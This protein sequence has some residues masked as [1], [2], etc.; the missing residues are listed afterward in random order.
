[1]NPEQNWLRPGC[2]QD[3]V[4]LVIFFFWGGRGGGGTFPLQAKSM[5]EQKQPRQMEKKQ[6]PHTPS[7]AGSSLVAHSPV[8]C[9][10]RNLPRRFHKVPFL[11]SIVTICHLYNTRAHLPSRLLDQMGLVM[12]YA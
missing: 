2:R 1:M 6:M 3:I 12:N 7:S 5:A 10:E 8:R 9:T 4:I 11:G